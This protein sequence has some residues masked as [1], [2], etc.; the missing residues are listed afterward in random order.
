MIVF[1]L[2]M[3]GKAS[4]N[5]KWS[6]EGRQYI[7]TR[8]ERDVPNDLWGKDFFY[9]WDDGWEACVSVTKL[10]A[11]EARKLEKMSAG[12]CSY[13]WMITS[14]VRYGRIMTEKEQAVMQDDREK[15]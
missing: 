12:F 13:D 11:K 9:R 14:L 5:G 2:S 8:H 4:W 3:P 1:E 7:R 6:G 15:L 10:P